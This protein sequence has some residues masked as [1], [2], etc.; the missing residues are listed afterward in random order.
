[1]YRMKRV[2][3]VLLLALIAAAAVAAEAPTPAYTQNGFS[4]RL[5]DA[6]VPLGERLELFNNVMALANK[7]QVRAQDLAGTLYWQGPAIEGSPVPRKLDQ[8]R[9]LLANSAVNGNLLA[10]A[11][12]AELELQAGRTDKA[13]V[14]AQLYARYRDPTKSIRARSRHNSGY[15][16]DLIERI[17]KA[18]G[19]TDKAIQTEV[20]G[21]VSLFD[22]R[23]RRGIEA[24]QNQRRS[25]ETFL[26]RRPSGTDKQ[27]DRNVNGLA[28]YMVEF[29]PDGKPGRIWLL[30]SLPGPR[31]DQVVRSHL[32]LAMANK[33]GAD[34]GPRYLKV[35]IEHSARRFKGLRPKSN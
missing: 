10:M 4:P 17:V 34:T 5:L 28:E 24:F 21:M 2:L 12:L 31:T 18:G 11:K 13:M 3:S 23:I 14:W 29:H 6:S 27:E 1:M 16:T 25:G 7:G 20:S 33:V 32:D 15:T 19:K 9:N 30:D 26:F 22:D 35:W 8:A